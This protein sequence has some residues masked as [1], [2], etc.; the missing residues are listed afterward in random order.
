MVDTIGLKTKPKDGK[1]ISLL[2][3]WRY[4]SGD[5]LPRAAPDQ[6]LVKNGCNRLTKGDEKRLGPLIAGC[7][8]PDK[9]HFL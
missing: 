3:I 6:M 5:W 4:L 9:R 2:C 1:F 8:A 7:P